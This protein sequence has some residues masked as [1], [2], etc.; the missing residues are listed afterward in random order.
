MIF[1]NQETS[2]G[3]F[4]VIVVGLN[5]RVCVCLVIV[6]TRLPKLAKVRQDST[7]IEVVSDHATSRGQAGPNI[8]FDNKPRLHSLLG[9]E[10]CQSQKRPHYANLPALSSHTENPSI[11][12]WNISFVTEKR[13]YGM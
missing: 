12:R 6:Y 4:Q 8:R 10:T 1:Q 13:K 9:Q 5:V 2:Y 3:L 11:T 7:G